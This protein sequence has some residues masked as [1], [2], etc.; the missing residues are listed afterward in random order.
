MALMQTLTDKFDTGLDKA[1]KW[2]LSNAGATWDSTNQRVQLACNKPTASVLGPGTTY[3]LTG[4]YIFAKI[5]IPPTGTGTR[6]IRLVCGDGGNNSLD[7]RCTG[8]TLSAVKSV[9]GVITSQSI[10][11]Y[12][13][14]THAFWR[15]RESGG[16]ALFDTSTDGLTWTNRWTTTKGITVTALYGYVECFYTGTESASNG[17]ADYVNALESFTYAVSTTMSMGSTPVQSESITQSGTTPFHAG[18]TPLQTETIPQSISTALQLGSIRV[19]SELIP[20]SVSTGFHTDSTALQSES[21]TQAVSVTFHTDAVPVIGFGCLTPLAMTS[22]IAMGFPVTSIMQL[23]DVIGN[24][25]ILMTEQPSTTT[26]EFSNALSV[27][28]QGGQIPPDRVREYLSSSSQIQVD[29]PYRL[30]AQRILDRVF[31]DWDLP[32]TDVVITYTLSG[33]KLIKG[34]FGPELLDYMDAGLEPKATYI[35]IEQDGIIR[36]S[37]IL[38]PSE[39]NEDASLTLI[40]EGISGYSHGQP[41]QGEYSQT[42]VDPLDVVRTIWSFLL[43]SPR[44]NLGLSIGSATS[45]VRVGNEIDLT[46][47]IVKP[48]ALFWWDDIDCGR[49]IDDLAK[50]TPFDYLEYD[51]WNTDKTDVDH[52]IILGYP[53]VG[54]RRFDLAFVSGENIINVALLREEPDQYASEVIV[55]GAG[56]GPESIRGYAANTIS[57]RIRQAVSVTD[58][59]ILT[60][61]AANAR[62]Q[63]ELRTRQSFLRIAEITI[64][65]HHDN[66]SLGEFQ[67]GDDIPVDVELYW[68][69]QVRMWC[70]VLSFDWYPQ[71]RTITIQLANSD[72]FTYGADGVSS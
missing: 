23:L 60:V 31:L 68:F 30:I 49:E 64:L 7:I 3:D 28:Q 18:S 39:I 65:D 11:A 58:K 29:K 51:V 34:K 26:L 69:G 27:I 36:G 20:Q 22:L 17:F 40:A 42:D 25:S 48:Y 55:R 50:N 67:P 15:V 71:N 10:G 6:V 12:N 52:H 33:P 46:N 61:E 53:R 14:T 9:S 43:A 45:P 47:D 56:E 2:S 59:T 16:N 57:N 72:I 41:Y 32:V 24:D 70:R 8:S 35:H 62:A 66:A 19:Q 5:V 63:Q 37:A 4:S 54:T 44:A 13:S 1:V 38:Q 21:I